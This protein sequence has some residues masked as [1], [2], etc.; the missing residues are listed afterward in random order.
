[1]F[2]SWI[3][4]FENDEISAVIMLD[5]SA[6]FDVVDHDNL[7]SKLHLYG[8]DDNSICWIKN[9][10]Y[11]RTQSVFVDGL[12]F[13]PLRVEYGI[14]QGSILGQL[15]YLMYTND[16]LEAIHGHH[17]QI[18][19]EGQ[20]H[21]YTKDCHSC[22]SICMYADDS[23]FTLSNSDAEVLNHEIDS[24]Y[25]MIDDYMCKNKLILNGDKTQF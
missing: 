7:L 17:N 11:S 21:T 18:Q 15:L 13:E 24:K 9:Y 19:H 3:D 14:P 1:M 20:G 25:K 4:A 8:L 6:A 2:D 10:L 12:L 22:G 16:L 5:M 23:T